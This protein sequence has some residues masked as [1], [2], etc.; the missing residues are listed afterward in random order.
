MSG[1]H[2]VLDLD[3][4]IWWCRVGVL[5]LL[6]VSRGESG[7]AGWF[8]EGFLAGRHASFVSFGGADLEPVQSP[9][10]D[11]GRPDVESGVAAKPVVEIDATLRVGLD[12]TVR[13][14]RDN[15]ARYAS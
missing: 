5:R 9:L 3:V 2:R 10:H 13:W 11:D 14:Y 12:R 4:C 6:L 15:R 8:G 7:S 1:T